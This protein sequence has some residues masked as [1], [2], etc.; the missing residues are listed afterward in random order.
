[1]L[2]LC[3]ELPGFGQI[4]YTT[5]DSTHIIWQPGMNLSFED[6]QG[7]PSEKEMDMFRKYNL[8]ASAAIGIW[9]VLNV[10]KKKRDRGKKREKVYFAPAFSKVGSSA[11]SP[12]SMQIAIQEVYFDIA[13]LSARWAR[14]ELQSMQ[15]KM[16]GYGTLYIMYTTVEKDMQD[17]YRQMIGVYTKEVIVEKKPGAYESWSAFYDEMLEETK[18]WATTPEE[19]HRQ[20]TG[21]PTEPGYEKSPTVA[22]PIY[23][24]LVRQGSSRSGFL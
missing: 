17:K 14:R 11:I 3:C 8:T 6:F 19:C 4:N 10:P 15:Y 24:V 1:M 12:D 22:G 21:K 20:L 2:I 13:E 18:E 23:P 16:N 9:S 5:E 7:I